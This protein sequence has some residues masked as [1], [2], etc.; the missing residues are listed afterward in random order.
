MSALTS[1]VVE[2]V[3]VHSKLLGPLEV[4]RTQIYEFPE[5]LYGLPDARSFALLPTERAGFFWLQS[6]EFEAL[7]FLLVDPFLFV[8]GYSVEVGREELGAL[9]ANDASELMVLAILSLPRAQGDAPTVNLQGPLLLNVV[10][11]IGKQ[12]VVEAPQGMRCPVDL[13][14]AA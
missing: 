7:T 8:D 2:D 9:S 5:E 1:A 14:R 4:M 6:V 13:N 3:L 10:D 12:V 11:R